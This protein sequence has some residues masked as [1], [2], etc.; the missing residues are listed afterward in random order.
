MEKNGIENQLGKIWKELESL[1]TKVEE[2]RENS[3]YE[4]AKEYKLDELSSN[5]LYTRG[6][7]LKTRKKI[8]TRSLQWRKD[9]LQITEMED[10][11]AVDAIKAKVE[12]QADFFSGFFIRFDESRIAELWGFNGSPDMEWTEAIR[13]V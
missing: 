5:L 11:E 9:L 13:V 10:K 6:V 3:S 8:P 4:Q 12:Y 2:I 1:L 7:V